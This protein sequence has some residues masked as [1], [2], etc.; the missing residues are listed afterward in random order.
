[1]AVGA[2]LTRRTTTAVTCCLCSQNSSI[3][4]GYAHLKEDLLLSGRAGASGGSSHTRPGMHERVTSKLLVP[5]SQHWMTCAA[6]QA[7]NQVNTRSMPSMGPGRTG[8]L[9]APCCSS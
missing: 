1:V 2:T 9:C 5:L 3:T 6:V 8:Q 4:H 7:A